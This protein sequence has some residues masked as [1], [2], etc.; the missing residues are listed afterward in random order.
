M[1]PLLTVISSDFKIS[2]RFFPAP[3][4][5]TALWTLTAGSIIITGEANWFTIFNAGTKH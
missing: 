5:L 3:Y 4:P 1:V 2:A